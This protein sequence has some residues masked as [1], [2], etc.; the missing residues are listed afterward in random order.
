MRLHGRRLELKMIAKEELAKTSS[1]SADVSREIEEIYRQHSRKVFATLV[2]LIGDFDLAEDAL[3]DAF[4]SAVEQWPASGVPANP[5]AWLTSA[6]RFR[7]IDFIRRRS[8]LDSLDENLIEFA[9][10]PADHD[11]F[12]PI[13]D[14]RLRLI[15]T[16]CHPAI[17]PDAQ[18]AL[19]LREVCGL[20]T[21]E[22]ARAFLT[23]ASTLAQRIVRAKGKIRDAR[24]PFAVPEAANLPERL[25]SV[26]RVVYLV[27]NEG[28][29]APSS[30]D[31]V[32]ENLA[33]EGIRLGRLMHELLPE[34]EVKGLLA[35]MLLNE[36][37]R[38]ARTNDQGE[39]ISLAD[40]DRSCW[41]KQM[42][43]EGCALV[44]ESLRSARFGPYALQAAISAV[45]SQSETF[46]TT[47]WY[48][49]AGLYRV[50]LS[51]Q[52]SPVVELNLAVARSMTEGPEV[53]IQAIESLM[54]RGELG[55][56]ALAQAALAEMHRRL[57][58]A[59]RAREFYKGAHRLAVLDSDRR[60]FA[61]K[62]AELNSLVGC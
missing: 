34:P 60:F 22:I 30:Q 48:E 38:N 21:E 43:A 16:C 23:T 3:H 55:G 12:E 49:I 24:I 31:P 1:A 6:G 37:R 27:F 41:N 35:L 57:G 44:E 20:T 52:P 42:I 59:D 11:G 53:G 15:F 13:E 29:S 46:E 51:V 18:V 33:A 17:A 7:A 61:R 26:L 19:T 2:R 8:R 39:W 36:S 45:H 56:Y 25:D 58:K 47:D 10:R 4:K 9:V 14:E 28:Y 62:L 5:L 40:Q 54:E 32:V 50:L